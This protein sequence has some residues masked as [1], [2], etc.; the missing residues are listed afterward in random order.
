MTK[1]TNKPENIFH[2]G[3]GFLFPRK[4]K[5]RKY[6]A[7]QPVLS[8]WQPPMPYLF[9]DSSSHPL[10]SY[11]LPGRHTATFWRCRG[12]C[13]SGIGRRRS[14]PR[15]LSVSQSMNRNVKRP[16]RGATTS[17]TLVSDTKTHPRRVYIW[18]SQAHFFPKGPRGN[19]NGSAICFTTRAKTLLVVRAWK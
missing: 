12:C 19:G 7:R 10:P 4:R 1:K 3:G 9:P 15:S 14:A 17:L 6:S 2:P 16:T 18:Q 11:S 8:G 5:S 13:D